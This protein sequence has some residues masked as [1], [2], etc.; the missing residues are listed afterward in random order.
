MRG[1]AA[2]V[3]LTSRPRAILFPASDRAS[4]VNG[5]EIVVDGG[6]TRAIMSLVPRPGHGS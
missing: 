2:P 1:F 5:D 4:Y 6:F 3:Y